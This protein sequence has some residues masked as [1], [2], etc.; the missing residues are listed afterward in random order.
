VHDKSH[1]RVKKSK[2]LLGPVWIFYRFRN[3]IR[4][5][6]PRHFGPEFFAEGGNEKKAGFC[7]NAFRKKEA[8]KTTLDTRGK[9]P[10]ILGRR[11][12]PQVTK[13][14]SFFWCKVASYRK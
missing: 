9:T 7:E 3:R 13:K 10:V 1:L 4:R 12:K 8:K 6:P 11:E 2:V 5:Q 14:D